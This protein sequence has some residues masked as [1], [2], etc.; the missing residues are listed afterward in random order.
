MILVLLPCLATATETL[1]QRLPPNGQTSCI[2]C[3]NETG[4]TSGAD[5]NPFGLDFRDT[6]GQIWGEALARM[7]SDSDG[8]TNGAEL[9][10]SD[11][12][13]EL[14]D[15]VGALTNPGVDGDCSAAAIDDLTWSELKN[16]FNGSR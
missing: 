10:D 14:D 13:G 5:L 7:D 8:C 11:G 3:H 4:P 15:G 16:L 2:S 9:N 6:P 1:M 12:N